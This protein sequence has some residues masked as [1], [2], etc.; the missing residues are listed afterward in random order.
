[1]VRGQSP[2][3]RMLARCAADAPGT[4]VW[5]VHAALS[6]EPGGKLG[7]GLICRW[8]RA[9][10]AGASVGWTR[11]GESTRLSSPSVKSVERA[12]TRLWARFW[13]TRFFE[14]C[15]MSSHRC[16]HLSRIT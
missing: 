11:R 13:V 9:G 7:R 4:A 2:A 15:G 6:R 8:T 12:E 3:R 1:M 10:R 14:F 5:W 16:V